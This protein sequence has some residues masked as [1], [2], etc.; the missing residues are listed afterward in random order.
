[1]ASAMAAVTAAPTGKKIT[2]D[3]F[4]GA[5]GSRRSGPGSTG[6]AAPLCG[7]A[8][9]QEIMQLLAGSKLSLQPSGLLT[10]TRPSFRG[11]LRVLVFRQ[12]WGV[13]A[14]RTFLVLGRSGR[15]LN[16]A[17]PFF[18]FGFLRGHSAAKD[19]RDLIVK[20]PQLGCGHGRPVVFLHRS[21]PQYPRTETE[22]NYQV[23][24]GSGKRDPLARAWA[25][26]N[27]AVGVTGR[28]RAFECAIAFQAP[29]PG[30]AASARATA[31]RPST[32]DY[33]GSAIQ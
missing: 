7:R 30:G 3:K 33:V 26:F 9:D 18:E 29:A 8:I 15:P 14:A 5:T 16:P 24:R 25:D 20:S 13:G 23:Q 2:T 6:P 27:L 28:A 4:C 31:A 32:R 22:G 17:K 10:A 11:I 21:R 1:M 19:S 12:H